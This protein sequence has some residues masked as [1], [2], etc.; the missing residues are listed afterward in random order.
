M[1]GYLAED[2]IIMWGRKNSGARKDF[3]NLLFLL[4]I[5]N[6]DLCPPRDGHM[7]IPKLKKIWKAMTSRRD[8]CVNTFVKVWRKAGCH[9]IQKDLLTA[10]ILPAYLSYGGQTFLTR[11]KAQNLSWPT[12][13]PVSYTHLT[14]PTNR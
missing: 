7:C 1:S 5:K 3:S 8:P 2:L 14:L 4:A 9:Y 12:S 13:G 11:P 10:A 6:S